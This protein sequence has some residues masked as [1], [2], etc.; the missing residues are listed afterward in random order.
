MAEVGEII[1]GTVTGIMPFGAFV[2]IG[3][4]KSGLVHISEVSNS[5]VKDIN[6]CLK[7][8]DKVKVKVLTVDDN[9]KISLSIKKAEMK[10][11]KRPGRIKDTR[12]GNTRPDDFNWLA[13]KD[14][15]LSFEDKLL[16]FKQ[17]SDENMRTVRRNA[18]S[19]RSGGYSRRGH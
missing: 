7:K 16:K 8:G 1:E 2:D 15:E 9:E 12:S 3:G 11:E 18:E 4:G 14:D 10:A 5:Y 6:D 19:K 13:K 17:V